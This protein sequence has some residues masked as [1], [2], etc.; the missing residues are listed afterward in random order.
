MNVAVLSS[1]RHLSNQSLA[2][3][4]LVLMTAPLANE[5]V[6]PPENI[7]ALLLII[8]CSDD[9]SQCSKLP[10][11]VSVFE[12]K[13]DCEQQLSNSLGGFTRQFEQLYAQCLPVDPAAE[14]EDTEPVWK[15]HPDGTLVASVKAAPSQQIESPGTLISLAARKRAGNL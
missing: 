15:F 10:V 1:L 12:T 13:E 6:S 9:L 2:L 5:D 7:A 14:D 3:V 4:V 11:P 8:G